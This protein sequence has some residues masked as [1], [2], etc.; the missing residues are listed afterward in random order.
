MNTKCW[1]VTA[2]VRLYPGPWRR[3]YGS[4]LED[5]LRT[6]PLS[7]HG[8]ADV[9]WNGIRLRLR[10]VDLATY[11]GLAAMLAVV[12]M[13]AGGQPVLSPS[14]MT[15]PAVAIP[16]LHS[17]LYA[18]FLFACGCAIHL[19]A[20]TSPSKTGLAAMKISFIAAVPILVAGLLLLTGALRP[21]AH[22]YSPGGWQ[23]LAAPI[24]T[25][26]GSWIW[27]AF[28]GFVGR[29]IAARSGDRRTHRA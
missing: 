21:D 12:G 15:F 13:A 7:A 10:S 19:H 6:R 14:H 26:G 22:S 18:L 1:I 27:G 20:R 4:E 8:I 3:E 9:A 23:V 25:L 11:F 16:P 29:A 2:L 24:A 5:L 17:D 28:G